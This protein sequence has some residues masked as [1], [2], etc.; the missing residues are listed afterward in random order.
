MVLEILQ[1]H[2]LLGYLAFET[3]QFF[4]YS[5]IITLEKFVF[6]EYFFLLVSQFFNTIKFISIAI[7]GLNA[8]SL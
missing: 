4:F 6:S 7:Q 5:L 1:S 8:L 3:F 2:R